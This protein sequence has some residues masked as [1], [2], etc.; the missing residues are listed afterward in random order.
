MILNHK[1]AIELLLVTKEISVESI[2]RL[3][4]LLADN[5]G[6]EQSRHFLE[7]DRSGAI[8]SHT[9][10]GFAVQGT[11]N[12][13]PEADGRP[14]KFIDGEFHRLV[15][16]ARQIT[17]PINQAAYL[18]TRIPYLQPFYDVNKRTSRI[19]CNIPLLTAGLAPMSFVGFDTNRY[20]GGL[21]AFYELGDTRL[22]KDTFLFAYLNS[23]FN[24][25][26]FN[27]ATRVAISTKR[28]ENLNEAARYVRE[29]QR[30]LEPLWLSAAPAQSSPSP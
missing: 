20:I 15:G 3:H 17:D 26:P 4:A 27:E 12:L 30:P 18:L 8:R 5:T 1:R 16:A 24:F 11:S 21:F 10:G 2:V 14:T 7:K 19:S 9:P 23:A 6:A 29:G 25:L 28:A 13:P 22:I